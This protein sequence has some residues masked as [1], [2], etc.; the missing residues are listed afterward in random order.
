MRNQDK[1][2]VDPTREGPRRG[3]EEEQAGERRKRGQAREANGSSSRLMWMRSGGSWIGIEARR[4]RRSRAAKRTCCRK[5]SKIVRES[6]REGWSDILK[7]RYA[8]ER[9]IIWDNKG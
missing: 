1:R 5:G 6:E 7:L 4:K 9:L 3:K 2:V 8:H